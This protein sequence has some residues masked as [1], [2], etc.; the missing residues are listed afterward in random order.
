MVRAVAGRRSPAARFAGMN[1]AA[2]HSAGRRGA[3]R[4]RLAPRNRT[5]HA[6]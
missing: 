6:P 1:P 4:L 2:A 3:G 5:R